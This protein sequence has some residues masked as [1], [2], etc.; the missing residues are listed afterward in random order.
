MKTHVEFRFDLFPAYPGE[1]E[2]I[3]PGICGRRPAEF[4]SAG[5]IQHGISTHEPFAENRGWI[6]PVENECFPLWMCHYQEY[7]D[8]FLCFVR[9]AISTIVISVQIR[10]A[11]S[12]R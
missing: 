12:R 2:E 6:V 7:P 5:L 8:G 1:Q 10:R 11:H 4:Q 9:K 3:N